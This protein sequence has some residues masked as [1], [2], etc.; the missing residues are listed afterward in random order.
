[1]HP[2]SSS[3]SVPGQGID[4]SLHAWDDCR[5]AASAIR[6]AVFVDEQRVPVQEELDDN[7]VHCLHAL[8]HAPDGLVVGTGRLLPDGHIGRMAVLRSWRGSGVGQALLLALVEA[9]RAR[10]HADVV[11]S[12]QLHAQG[13]YARHGFV[14]HGEVYQDAGIAHIAMRRA[15]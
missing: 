7:D 14:A 11:L 13:F 4:I 9:A 3:S 15:L 1:M 2:H 10:G 8:A 5:D 12:A 6:H